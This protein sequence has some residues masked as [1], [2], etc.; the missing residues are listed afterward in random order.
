MIQGLTEM[1]D[2]GKK[3]EKNSKNDDERLKPLIEYAKIKKS[4]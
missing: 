2:F 4:L 1:F 3:N